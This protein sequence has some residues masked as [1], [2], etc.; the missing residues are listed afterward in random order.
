MSE[1]RRPHLDGSGGAT[2]LSLNVRARHILGLEHKIDPAGK[3]ER[4]SVIN[5]NVMTVK[6]R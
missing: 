1:T 2:L 3:W 5:I 4:I 6:E